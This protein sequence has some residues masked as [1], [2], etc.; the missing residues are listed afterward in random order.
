MGS[1]SREIGHW[2]HANETVGC[3][4]AVTGRQTERHSSTGSFSVSFSQIHVC[5]PMQCAQI[6]VLGYI[7]IDNIRCSG[8]TCRLRESDSAQKS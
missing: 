3:Y 5:K 1:K 6:R 7:M 4:G 8:R 2:S